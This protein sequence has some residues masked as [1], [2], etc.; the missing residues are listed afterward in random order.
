MNKKLRWAALLL[1]VILLTGCTKPREP[2]IA[3]APPLPT[4]VT[5]PADV[6]PEVEP[7]SEIDLSCFND[8]TMELFK[9]S[10]TGGNWVTAPAF[11]A[12]ALESLL[13]GADGD[14]GLQIRSVL[15]VPEETE[16]DAVWSSLRSQR[17]RLSSLAAGSLWNGWGLMM[18]EGPSLRID[19]T[20]LLGQAMDVKPV[21]VDYASDGYGDNFTAWVNTATGGFVT[22]ITGIPEENEPL[23]LTAAAV[24]DGKWSKAFSPENIRNA[25]FTGKNGQAVNTPMMTG[26]V[27]PFILNN[28]ECTFAAMTLDGSL[29]AWLVLP[30]KDKTLE[31]F[32]SGLTSD[33]LQS[34]RKQAAA[35]S[36]LVAIPRLD[37]TCT[38]DIS[39]ALTEMGLD[40]PFSAEDADFSRIGSGLSVSS[41][42]TAFRLRL[43]EA[44]V[45]EGDEPMSQRMLRGLD[46]SVPYF[47]F[48]RPYLLFIAEKRTGSLIAAA[49]ILTPPSEG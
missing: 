1:L 47:C 46:Q 40:L 16:T 17:N 36:C 26:K 31:D 11:A 15:G 12:V 33:E 30:P 14:T 18:G 49:G 43:T 32:L 4:A 6:L 42:L 21:L 3:S 24:L 13:P 9:R 8:F 37:I 23:V 48:D 41:L 22:R 35:A 29:E 19:Y 45:E 10:Y 39:P 27:S 38:G 2:L 25:P 5:K 44:G 7:D 20:E 34:W 28:T